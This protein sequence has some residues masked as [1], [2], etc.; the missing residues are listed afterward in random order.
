[1]LT[2]FKPV[3]NLVV[4]FLLWASQ[5]FNS[6]SSAFEQPKKINSH[7]SY[8]L[9]LRIWMNVKTSKVLFFCWKRFDMNNF[10]TESWIL[11]FISITILQQNYEY[12]LRWQYF[13]TFKTQIMTNTR[14]LISS[15]PHDPVVKRIKHEAPV[16]LTYCEKSSN[17]ARV[18]LFNNRPAL[19]LK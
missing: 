9:K 12:Y 11:I 3:K 2:D 6:H 5:K 16:F 4:I 14:A 17:P 15:K 10:L 1:M 7:T 19:I 8:L 13:R 18:R